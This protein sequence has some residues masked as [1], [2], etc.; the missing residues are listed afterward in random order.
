MNPD[1]PSVAWKDR[2]FRLAWLL[3]ATGFAVFMIRWHDRFQAPALRMQ[4]RLGMPLWHWGILALMALGALAAWWVI[5]HQDT[6]LKGLERERR[7]GLTLIALMLAGNGF[8]MVNA[9][10]AIHYLQY[11]LLTLLL[12]P[13]FRSVLPAVFVS[14]LFG[15]A[16]EWY[17]MMVL[18]PDWQGYV[19]F[20]DM[21]MNTIGATAGGLIARCWWKQDEPVSWWW[22]W[23]GL[24]LVVILLF[25]TSL[26]GVSPEG[27]RWAMV[28]W[29]GGNPNAF[30]S[31]WIDTG[32]GNHWFMLVWRESL[33]LMW[34][35]PWLLF[36]RPGKTHPLQEGGHAT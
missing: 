28:R 6:L 25:Q 7:A 14:V 30:L 24:A 36:R 16:D 17:Q 10:E 33:P 27:G 23:T 11:G 2:G 31:R 15:V 35:I 13:A 18:H 8:L 5:R 3:T 34:L 9:V 32:W 22:I 26:L 12:V 20:N 19:D 1:S 21:V 4:G 29:G